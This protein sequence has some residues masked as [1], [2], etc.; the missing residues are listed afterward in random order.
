MPELLVRVV[1]KVNSDPYLDALCTK[2]GDVIVVKPDGWAWGGKE[3]DN[4]EWRII[5]LDAPEAECLQF[6]SA[7]LPETATS[8]RMVRKRAFTFDIEAFDAGERRITKLLVRKPVLNDPKVFGPD[9]RV[10]G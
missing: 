10:I 4:S 2:R 6:I 1:D 5:K 9:K 7:E 8:N 3:R